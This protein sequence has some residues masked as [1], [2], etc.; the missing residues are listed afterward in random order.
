MEPSDW[1]LQALAGSRTSLGLDPNSIERSKSLHAPK[2][3][4]LEGST[5]TVRRSDLRNLLPWWTA[6]LGHR[7]LQSIRSSS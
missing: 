4:H 6:A 7:C 5:A 3:S 2:A 1:L